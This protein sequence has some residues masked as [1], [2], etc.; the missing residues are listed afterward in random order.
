MKLEKIIQTDGN[1]QVVRRY[2]DGYIVVN[3]DTVETSAVLTPDSLDTNWPPQAFD[4]LETG[5]LEALLDKQPDMILLGTGNSQHFPEPEL[6][7]PLYRAG[8][9]V[10]V[11]DTGAACRTFNIIMSE[12]RRVVA[13]LLMTQPETAPGH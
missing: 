9:G 1:S 12:G 11:M 7:A 13:A 8:I 3:D 5:H 4:D 10:E 2:G 6:L